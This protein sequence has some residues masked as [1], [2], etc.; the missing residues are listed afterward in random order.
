MKESEKCQFYRR[1]SQLKFVNIDYEN[2]SFPENIQLMKRNNV[3]PYY[4]YFDMIQLNEADIIVSSFSELFDPK[5][6]I[7]LKN[8]LNENFDDYIVIIDDCENLGKH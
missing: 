1:R 4:F 5:T 6:R 7:N 2:N 3:C 8:V